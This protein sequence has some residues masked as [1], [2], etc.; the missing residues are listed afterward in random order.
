MASKADFSEDEWKAME[1]GVTGAGLLV[2]ASDPGFFDTFSESVALA[3]ELAAEHK[4]S[5]NELVRE[6]AAP[7]GTGFGLATS[8]TELETETLGALRSAAAALASKA[9]DDLAA[10]RELV[11]AVAD[12]VADAKGGVKPGETAAIEKLKDALGTAQE[13]AAEV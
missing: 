13:P 4:S 12:R 11:L 7:H 9:P 2:A 5:E 8:S 3:K 10:Y 1:K 6:L